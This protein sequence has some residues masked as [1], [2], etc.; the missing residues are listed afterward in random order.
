MEKHMKCH[1]KNNLSITRRAMPAMLLGLALSLVSIVPLPATAY[2]D[3]EVDTTG[4][5]RDDRGTVSSGQILE[6]GVVSAN[7][8]RIEGE[9]YLK[10]GQLEKALVVLQRS[11]E[12][13]PND[14]DNRVLYATAL[15]RKLLRQPRLSRDPGLFNFVVKNW[16]CIAK[17]SEFADQTMEAYQHMVKLT[18]TFPKKREKEKA[19]LK[20]VLVPED[21]S[22]TVRIGGPSVPAAQTAAK[23]ETHD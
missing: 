6:L 13:A 9:N 16:L 23:P 4:I 8:L 18:G 20:R 21:G 12:M 19:F 2:D 17:G 11:V 14:M 5:G 1:K 10:C 3:N 22:V 15:E 7:G